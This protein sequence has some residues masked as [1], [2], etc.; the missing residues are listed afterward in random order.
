MS[1]VSVVTSI[2]IHI[3]GVLLIPLPKPASSS[4]ITYSHIQSISLPPIASRFTL[5]AS[6]SPTRLFFIIQS[7]LHFSIRSDLRISTRPLVI[8]F[9]NFALH[10]IARV[11]SS[12]VGYREFINTRHGIEFPVCFIKHHEFLSQLISAIF[13]NTVFIRVTQ[14]VMTVISCRN[15]CDEIDTFTRTIYEFM[16]RMRNLLLRK[17]PINLSSRHFDI[18]NRECRSTLVTLIQG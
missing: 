1:P 9:L 17:T 18:N 2:H 6:S 16:S 15:F 4:S 5:P 11:L 13:F 14:L 12:S 7:A 10:T 3:R 8:F